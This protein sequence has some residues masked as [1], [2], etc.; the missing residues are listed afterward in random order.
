MAVR[1][2]SILII[3]AFMNL[4][5]FPFYVGALLPADPYEGKLSVKENNGLVSC[6][7]LM[8]MAEE[9]NEEKDDLADDEDGY[10][11]LLT[12]FEYHHPLRFGE[13][14]R[15][16]RMHRLLNNQQTIYCPP[17]IANKA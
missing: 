2:K 9:N 8:I 13:K 10:S 17:E 14:I 12:V 11:F 15:Q 5:V 1:F 7:S 16:E 3:V 6:I 4:L